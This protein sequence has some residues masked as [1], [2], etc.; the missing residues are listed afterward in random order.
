MTSWSA[1]WPIVW[2]HL[3]SLL[4]LIAIVAIGRWLWLRCV[5]WTRR[6]VVVRTALLA[7]VYVPV[8]AE[9]LVTFSAAWAF[10]G[11]DPDFG[12]ERMLD[13]TASRPY[14]YRRL[15]ADVI[16]ATSR[17]AARVLPER[18]QRYLERH[19]RVRRY[20]VMADT[21]SSLDVDAATLAASRP[22]VVPGERWNR[23][24]ALD[25]H[26]AYAFVFLCF[27]GTLW[28]ARALTRAARPDAPLFADIAPAV[29]LLLLPY[30]FLAGGYFYDASELLLV[31]ASALCIVRRRPW[32]HLAVFA[33]A[34]CN[35]E[36]DVLLAP[37]ALVAFLGTM[38]RRRWWLVAAAHGVVGVALVL[39]L[40]HAYAGN[41]G[42]AVQ[43]HL[44]GNVAFWTDPR[45]YLRFM[46][47]YA[48]LIWVP[49]GANLLTVA[50]VIVLVGTGWRETAPIVRR[51]F[52]ATLALTMPLLVLFCLADEL[53]NLSLAFPALY[54]VGCAGVR[55][56]YA[57]DGEQ[58][59]TPSGS[60]GRRPSAEVGV[61]PVP[62]TPVP[63]TPVPVTPVPVTPVRS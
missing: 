45:A 33:L 44:W 26:A 20:A 49:R 38:P 48:P 28:V 23:R 14:V 24:K 29:G 50:A 39:A 6:R 3:P 10:R 4:A 53:R 27:F 9:T 40:R 11:D 19:S 63:V 55:R 37:A 43:V 15:G 41:V 32:W 31:F 7:M 56:L 47:I 46:D 17:L 16:G 59:R 58:Y 8:A 60:R 42:G 61:A 25:F 21:L 5:P 51:L 52:V 22:P 34:V 13:G 36:A 30:T 35:K 18:V 1:A 57:S 2:G 54:L 62:V 12:L